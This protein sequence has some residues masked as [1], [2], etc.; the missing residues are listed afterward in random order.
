VQFGIITIVTV[1][2][3]TALYLAA[4][5]DTPSRLFRESRAIAAS[6]TDGLI[7]M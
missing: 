1:G 2:T 6:D 3:F 5:A 7:D 4:S